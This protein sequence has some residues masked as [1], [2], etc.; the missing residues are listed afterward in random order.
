M[1][2]GKKDKSIHG[3]GHQSAVF[4]AFMSQSNFCLFSFFVCFAFS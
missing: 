4:L 3:C 2:V 1:T